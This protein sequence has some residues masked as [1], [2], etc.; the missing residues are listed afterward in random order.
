MMTMMR[1]MSVNIQ[2]PCVLQG[3]CVCVRAC[4]HPHQDIMQGCRKQAHED[5]IS[6]CQD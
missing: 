1:T 6:K 4:I 5:Q 3:Q 2:R